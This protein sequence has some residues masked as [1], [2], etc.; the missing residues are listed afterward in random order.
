[1]QLYQCLQ[2]FLGQTVGDIRVTIYEPR[3]C[4][5]HPLLL[6]SHLLTHRRQVAPVPSTAAVAAVEGASTV[7]DLL[8]HVADTG[9]SASG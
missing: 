1:M 9:A 4:V 8:L 3:K 2:P 6:T 7:G 5:P